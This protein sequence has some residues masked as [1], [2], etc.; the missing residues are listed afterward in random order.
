MDQ[1]RTFLAA[2]KKHHFWILCGLAVLI[3]LGMTI[4]AKSKLLNSYEDEKGKINSAQTSV[5]PFATGQDHPNPTWIDDAKAKTVEAQKKVFDA[6]NKLYQEQAKSVFQWPLDLTEDQAFLKE[7]A[8]AD[9]QTEKKLERKRLDELA[10]RYIS[11]IT[12]V[13]LPRLATIIDAEWTAGDDK[14]AARRAAAGP[15]A[16]EAVSH[17][18]VWD[19]ADQQSKFDNYNWQ[20]RPSRLDMQYAQE[21]MWVMEALFNAIKRANSDAKGSYD[22]PVRQLTEVRVGYDATN[23]YPL[24]EGAGRIIRTMHAVIPG[25]STS[26]PTGGESSAR[27]GR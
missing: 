16:A 11:Y 23:R 21:E 15:D 10:Y 17:K 2:V 6:W 12:K 20:E 5:A 4:S 1:V 27:R 19:S 14:D 8:A 7:F 18:V 13:T 22:A 26:T 24:G 25:V 3:G 9:D